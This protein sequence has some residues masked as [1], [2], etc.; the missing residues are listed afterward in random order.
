MSGGTPLVHAFGRTYSAPAAALRQA[1]FFAG[2]IGGGYSDSKSEVSL[3]FDDHNITKDAFKI[4]LDCLTTGEL[5]DGLP[6]DVLLSLIATSLYL[7]AQT[8]TDM[9]LAALERIVA[10]SVPQILYFCATGTVGQGDPGEDDSRGRT[11]YGAAAE[12]LASMCT[13]W[14]LRHAALFPD[15]LTEIPGAT[16][17]RVLLSDRLFIYSERQRVALAQ[18]TVESRSKHRD[19]E[20][21]LPTEASLLSSL[22]LGTRLRF[23]FDFGDVDLLP[24]G[25]RMYSPVHFAAG[26]WWCMCAYV[27][28]DGRTLAVSVERRDPAEPLPAP[29]RLRTFDR[30]GH[31]LLA[32]FFPD[33]AQE[34]RSDL[35]SGN[36]RMERHRRAFVCP[37]LPYVDKR[38]RVPLKYSL[39]DA[40]TGEWIEMRTFLEISE[41]SWEDEALHVPL[42]NVQ[43]VA[44]T[45]II[46]VDE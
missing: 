30:K 18:N 41:Q 2:L 13:H 11:M 7:D 35:L 19:P 26:S 37:P 31:A 15:I 20:C 39:R 22:S 23:S 29:L 24:Q 6:A 10:T 14:L 3:E 25:E 27:Y 8:V 36:A 28:D 45:C 17:K 43:V 33:P 38:E 34:N 12:R 16:L 21:I 4:C 40:D 5:R 42:D 1:G 32:G 9:T 46:D 44:C